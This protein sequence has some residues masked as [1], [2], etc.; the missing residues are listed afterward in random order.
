[1][2]TGKS[3]SLLI[4]TRK[5]AFTLSSDNTRKNWSL[6]EPLFLGHVIYH[7]VSDGNGAGAM[8][9][10]AKTGH[11][12]P[13]VF[14]ST[15]H[16]KKWTEAET[17]PA[18]PKVPEGEK[19][20]VVD[21]V[22]WLTKA[23]GN[24]NWYAGTAPAGLFRSEDNGKTWEAISGFN[25]HPS[26]AKWTENGA[27]PGGQFL[28]SIIVN[29][30]DESEMYIGISV[31]GIFHSRDAGKTWKPLNK[32]VA[33]DFMPDPNLDYGHDPHCIAMHPVKTD[34]L[35]HQNHC[36]IY[37]LDRPS[38]EWVRIGKNMPSE[39]GDIG[40]P[41]VLHPTNA[42]RAWV[43][44]M[45]GT[46]VWP[47][48]SPGGKPAVYSTADGGKSWKRHDKGLPASNAYFTVKRQAMTGDN[49][50]TLGLYFGT[51]QGEVWGSFDEGESWQLLV[52][53]LPEIYSLAI[54]RS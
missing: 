4:G 47:R 42:D 37:R 38:E 43:F 22:F 6:S 13:T 17:P 34:R 54:A 40:F 35:Y 39:V 16:G 3:L 8:L 24:G 14:R 19:G 29:P 5:G 11:L 45:D 53:H 36:G 31:G 26:Y 49:L 2:A 20:R 7:F 18:F 10:A 48:T 21:S 9:M 1:M 44:P 50:D 23:H 15:D 30:K 33:A 52:R 25:D 32:G 12:G 41:I 28:H 46:E 51:T 27:T